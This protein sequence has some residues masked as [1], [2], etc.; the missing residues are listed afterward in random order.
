MHVLMHKAC[1]THMPSDHMM[2][3][4]VIVCQMQCTDAGE[5]IWPWNWLVLNKCLVFACKYTAWRPCCNQASLLALYYQCNAT[6][7]THVDPASAASVLVLWGCPLI[8]C[9]ASKQNNA[10]CFP[11]VVIQF[12]LIFCVRAGVWRQQGLGTHIWYVCGTLTGDGGSGGG[13]SGGGLG[14]S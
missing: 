5:S 3:A 12:P 9:V 13:G 10:P 7:R 2:Y 14:G 1:S 4:S 8:H 11:G 6:E